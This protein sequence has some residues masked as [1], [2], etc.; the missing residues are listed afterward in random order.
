MIS[1]RRENCSPDRYSVEMA[2]RRETLEFF[3]RESFC[4]GQGFP[5]LAG[6]PMIQEL[7]LSGRCRLDQ[8]QIILQEQ[9]AQMGSDLLTD[10]HLLKRVGVLKIRQDKIRIWSDDRVGRRECFFL[11]LPKLMCV[12]SP[13]SQV[14]PCHLHSLTLVRNRFWSWGH[15]VS[16]GFWE[17]CVQL[18]S[19]DVE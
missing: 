16:D 1:N 5:V 13:S 19:P 14:M 11:F 3:Q 6:S 2:R 7:F 4:P 8:S 9:I 15:D 10:V 18:V 12:T 17:H